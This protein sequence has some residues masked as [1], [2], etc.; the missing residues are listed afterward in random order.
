MNDYVNS[1]KSEQRIFSLAK[2]VL[3]T[4]W[5]C[6]EKSWKHAVKGDSEEFITSA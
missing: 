4:W 2:V 1:H 3:E 5:T 6:S